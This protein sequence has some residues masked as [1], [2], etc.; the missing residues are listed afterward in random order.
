MY[1]LFLLPGDMPREGHY[2]K[3]ITGRECMITPRNK[4]MAEGAGFEPAVRYRT[5]VFKTAAFNH[6]AIPPHGFT[7]NRWTL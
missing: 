6:S 4:K 3:M 7:F 5:T 1:F 2:F